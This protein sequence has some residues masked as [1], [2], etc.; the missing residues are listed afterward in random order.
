MTGA[1]VQALAWFLP[2]PPGR[3]QHQVASHQPSGHHQGGDLFQLFHAHHASLSASGVPTQGSLPSA[4]GH[5]SS[6]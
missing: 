4:L 6:L 3:E 1:I 2:L 5:R